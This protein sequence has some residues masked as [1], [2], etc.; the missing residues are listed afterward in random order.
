MKEF[1]VNFALS[2][3]FAASFTIAWIAIDEIHASHCDGCSWYWC[4][5]YI[6]EN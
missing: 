5:N 1:I 3:A 4:R 2:A 6:P